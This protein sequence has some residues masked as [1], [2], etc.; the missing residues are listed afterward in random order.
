MTPSDPRR[1][2]RAAVAALTL[3][4]VALAGTLAL[5]ADRRADDGR[6]SAGDLIRRAGTDWGAPQAGPESARQREVGRAA[7]R[8][9]EAFLD[10]DYRDMKP[11]IAAVQALATGTFK[12]Q[13]DASADDVITQV[14][15]SRSISSGTV[16]ALGVGELDHDSALVFVAANS[17]VRNLATDGTAQPRYY[18]LQLTMQRV[19]GAWLASSVDFVG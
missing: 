8:V 7:A 14:T 1:R 18:R 3:L 10:V 19:D 4:V 2:W 11:R 6:F 16:Q 15:Q 17:S 12:E 13:F 9:T 5:V